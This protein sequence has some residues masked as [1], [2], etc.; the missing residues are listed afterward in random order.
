MNPDYILRALV[1]GLAY[2]VAWAAPVWLA[3]AVLV[4]LFVAGWLGRL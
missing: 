1:R 2:R 4:V 3:A